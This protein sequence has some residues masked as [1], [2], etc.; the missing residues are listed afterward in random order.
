MTR[1]FR[2]L[3]QFERVVITHE[4]EG[5]IFSAAAAR[6]RGREAGL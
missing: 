6:A 4:S 2:R 5:N 1:A 3:V